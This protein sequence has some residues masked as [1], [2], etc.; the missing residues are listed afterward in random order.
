M[1]EELRQFHRTVGASILYVTHDQQEAASMA[2]RIAIM[3]HGKAEQIGSPHEVYDQPSNSFVA[4]FL[5]EANMFRLRQVREDGSGHVRCDTEEGL[6]V[7]A[8]GAASGGAVACIR[9]EDITIATTPM[10]RDYFF[11]GRIT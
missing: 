4:Q 7:L 8:H 9:P 6:S 2:D 3:N 10:G 1:Q 5:G 11:A